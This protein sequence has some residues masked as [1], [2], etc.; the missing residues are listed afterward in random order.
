MHCAPFYGVKPVFI[1][2]SRILVQTAIYLGPKL[3]LDSSG[4]NFDFSKSTALHSGKYL[5][6]MLLRDR[7]PDCAS[8]PFQPD[9]TGSFLLANLSPTTFAY[10]YSKVVGDGGRY[11][12]PSP[13]PARRWGVSVRTFLPP[14]LLCTTINNSFS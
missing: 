5:A 14:P 3:L 13:P 2:I 9:L 4:T 8:G 10:K 6:P 12:L 11:P 7:G 1:L